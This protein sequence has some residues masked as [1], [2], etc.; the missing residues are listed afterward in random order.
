MP[1]FFFRIVFAFVTT[2]FLGCADKKESPFADTS[3]TIDNAQTNLEHMERFDPPT[4][5]IEPRNEFG[6]AKVSRRIKDVHYEGIIDAKG[7]AVVPISS[8]LFVNDISG[9]L[10]L[11]QFERKFL[12]VPLDGSSYS[13]E[14]FE[15]VKGF[16][17]AKPYRCGLA[18]VCVDD[19]WFYINE[20]FQKAFDADFEFAESFHQDRALVK[21][22]E[23]Y[24]IIGTDGNTVAD[25]NYDQV[26][27]QSEYC[28]QVIN[29]IDGKYMSGFVDLNGVPITD[30]IYENVSYYDPD[31]KRIRVYKDERFGFVD[32]HAKLVIPLKYEY[33]RPFFEHGKV[34]VT[35][36]GRTFLIDPNG[37]EVPE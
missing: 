22:N 28:W 4:E 37:N 27:L 6:F 17:H 8:R 16:Q 25:L 10:A 26:S 1:R 12:F 14:D 29:K 33:A 23:R 11:I 32:E 13:E 20:E 36:D 35:V 21:A 34:R 2:T 24:R 15:G 9:K 31:V 19:S 30:L 18:M 5:K 3:R 7:E